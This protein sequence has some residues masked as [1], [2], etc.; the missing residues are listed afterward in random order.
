M[1]QHFDMNVHFSTTKAVLAATVLC[2]VQ[3]GCASGDEFT[4]EFL[5]QLPVGEIGA[6]PNRTKCS[7]L[8]FGCIEQISI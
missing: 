6:A 5:D 1:R 4:P 7:R 3:V 2:A 8:V